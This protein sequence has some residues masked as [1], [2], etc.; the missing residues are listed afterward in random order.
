[1]IGSIQTKY[2]GRGHC[3]GSCGFLVKIENMLTGRSSRP[4]SFKGFK[5]S[6]PKGTCGFKKGQDGKS[7]IFT[8]ALARV[9]VRF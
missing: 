6:Y 7:A 5:V 1:V 3:Q 8:K 2:R 4:A 9:V